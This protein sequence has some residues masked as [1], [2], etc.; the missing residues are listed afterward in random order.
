MDSPI[1][2]FPNHIFMFFSIFIFNQIKSFTWYTSKSRIFA[3]FN[4]ELMSPTNFYIFQDNF[5]FGCDL[6]T[7]KQSAKTQKKLGIIDSPNL[8]SAIQISMF[9]FLS[10]FFQPSK[11]FFLIRSKSQIMA[12]CNLDQ[13]NSPIFCANN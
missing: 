6:V 13:S 9:F 10:S 4:L 7:S 12:R 1:F 8:N 3:R 2:E 5:K 11:K